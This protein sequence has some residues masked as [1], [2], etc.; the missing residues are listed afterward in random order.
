MRRCEGYQGTRD[1]LAGKM[2]EGAEGRRCLWQ[3]GPASG[4]GCAEGSACVPGGLYVCERVYLRTP[5]LYTR[6]HA[7]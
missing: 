6:E 2:D 3:E 1:R 5:E 4:G 7:S